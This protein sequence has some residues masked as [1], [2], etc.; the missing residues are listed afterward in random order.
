MGGS[1]LARLSV[2]A[3]LLA[4]ITSGGSLTDGLFAEPKVGKHV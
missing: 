2:Q 3:H 1:V 4:V